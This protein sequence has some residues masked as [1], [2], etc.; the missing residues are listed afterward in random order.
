M[1][2]IEIIEK[3][4]QVKILNYLFDHFCLG[5]LPEAGRRA[6]RGLINILNEEIKDTQKN[7]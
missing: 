1:T 7:K 6:I 4:A 3:R 5:E 2:E